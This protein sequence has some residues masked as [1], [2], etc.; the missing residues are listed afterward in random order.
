MVNKK[1]GILE[2]VVLEDR[3]FKNG[4]WTVVLLLFFGTLAF[5]LWYVE[6]Q[7]IKDWLSKR[8]S[9][10]EFLTNPDY[11]NAWDYLWVILYSISTIEFSARFKTVAVKY[12][13]AENLK[14]NTEYE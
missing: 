8:P 13:N 14:Y 5:L 2:N 7:I 9:V 6:L 12:V 1:T 11:K 3:D 4:M 10:K